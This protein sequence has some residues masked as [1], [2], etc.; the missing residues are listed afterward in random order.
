M[1]I[2]PKEQIRLHTGMSR[3]AAELLLHCIVDPKRPGFLGG[4]G[5]KP[6]WGW[7]DGTSFQITPSA[8]AG[9]SFVPWIAGR[10]SAGDGEACLDMRME[11][12]DFVKAFMT[13]WQLGLAVLAASGL[14]LLFISGSM[15]N[16][17]LLSLAAAGMSG[18]G[19]GLLRVGFR[20]GANRAKAELGRYF[21]P[22]ARWEK[23]DGN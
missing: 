21:G 3:E 8:M 15:K 2:F 22:A 16:G 20:I 6:F 19:W 23:T 17:C 14:V 13:A 11:P 9:N 1:R 12:L 5:R 7:F 18:F 4:S 10:F